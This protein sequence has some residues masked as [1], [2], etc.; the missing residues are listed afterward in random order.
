MGDKEQGNRGDE[1]SFKDYDSNNKNQWC[2]GCGDFGIIHS[3]RLALDNMKMPRENVVV[4]SGIGCSGKTPHYMSTYGIESIHGRA[5]PVATGVLLSNP[6]LTVIVN[7]GDGDCYG[8][9][10]GHLIHAMRRN[11]NLT[12]IVHNNMVYGLTKGQTSPTSG[13]GFKTKST[14]HG[15][16]DYPV[17]PLLLALSSGATFVARGFSG[18]AIKLSELIMKGIEHK[19]FSL[20]DI[21]QPCISFNIINTYGYFQEKTYSLESEGHNPNDFEGAIKK[22]LEADRY[23]LGI[24]YQERKPTYDEQVT[25]NN[26]SPLV[27]E[28]ISNVDIEPMLDGYEF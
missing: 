11:L 13:K 5:I 17:N 27:E 15:S 12:V 8:I 22:S 9:G 4:V 7:T 25:Q 1:M 14:P 10:M 23:G 3:L 28:D 20:I 19:G 16:I 2:P 21:F 24:F 26:G 18:D 6:K